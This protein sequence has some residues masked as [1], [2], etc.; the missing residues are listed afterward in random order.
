MK[1]HDNRPTLTDPPRNGE[2]VAVTQERMVVEDLV[3]SGKAARAKDGELPPG[4]THE[5][6]GQESDGRYIVV[7]RRFNAY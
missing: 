6:I 7:R 2:D 3:A 5:I 1:K 4:A